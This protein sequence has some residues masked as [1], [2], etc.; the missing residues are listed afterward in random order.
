MLIKLFFIILGLYLFFLVSVRW[1]FP[2]L[3]RWYL[4]RTLKKMEQS[5][6]P[7]A[8]RKINV[9]RKQKSYQPRDK[10]SNAEYIDFEEIRGK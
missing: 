1:L 2:W 5:F 4:K 9:K 6:Y 10:Y 8:E 7:K 3:V